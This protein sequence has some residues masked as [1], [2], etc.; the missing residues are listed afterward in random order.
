VSGHDEDEVVEVVGPPPRAVV[1]DVGE[2]L[3]D[4]TRVWST[5]A[6]L[7]GVS[8]LTFAS[9]LGAAV[10]Q[11]EDH[12]AVFE[13]VAPNVD[14]EPLE[15]EHER[16]YGGFRED[17]LYPDVRPALTELREAG[18]TVAI[19]GNQPARRQAQLEAL[20]LP[21]DH[22]A[23]SELLGHE[24]PAPAFYTAV[25]DLLGLEDPAEVL[26]VGDRV[27]ND[28][29]PAAAFGMRTCWLRRGPWGQL[30]D[31]PEDTDADLVLD[32]LG[33]LPLLLT[34]WRDEH[35]EAHG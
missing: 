13:H 6:E 33:E 24:K 2:V 18:F 12:L 3:V 22:V 21:G 11:G 5:W 1:F 16:R 19:A 7:L 32:G 31:L 8:G 25:L 28:V 35:E 4:E 14:W 23:M 29:L 30:Q 27:D 9:V 15:E 34:Q 26:Y 20:D 10:V 17:D